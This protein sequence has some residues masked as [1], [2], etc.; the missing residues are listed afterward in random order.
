MN[1]KKVVKYLFLL[2]LIFAA[3]SKNEVNQYQFPKIISGQ[4]RSS[5]GLPLENVRVTLTTV[6][7]FNV[8]FTNQQGYYRIENVPEG[9]HRIK[10]E[11]YGYE[12]QELDVPS[13]INGVST[14]NVQLNKKVYSTPTNK[15]VSK[16]PVRIFNNRLE[17]DFD[18]DGIYVPFFVKG[19]AFSPTPIG[20]RPITPKME[21]RSIQFLK[22]LNVNTIRTYSGVRSSLLEKLAMQ[23]IYCVLGFWVDYNTDLSKPDNREK[24]KQDFIRFVYQ[25]K[26]NPGLLMWNLGNEQ[27]YQN[28]NNQYWYSLAQ[29]LALI[30]YNIEGEKYHPVVI[31]NG[32]I[33]NIGNP[34]M[35]ADDNS[36]TYIDVW[37]INLYNYNL[38]SRINQIRNK[39][40]KLVLITEFG[41]DALDN[42]TK[43][44]YETTQAVFDSLNWQQILSVADICLGGTVFEFTDEWWKDKDPWNHDYG[45]YPTNQHPDG[46]SNEEWWGLIRVLPDSD[47]DG[48]DEWI[49]REVYYMFKR[50]WKQ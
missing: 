9:K 7:N 33:F 36:L 19:V 40:I 37:G 31:N 45:G 13:A 41:I 30:A 38:A 20:N 46:Y 16:G 34:A 12:E 15:P 29:E 23:G 39:T 50:N 25:Y 43:Q 49:P 11:L 28:G 35:L 32:E 3:C 2:V 14:V 42:R 48:L 10:F 27:N 1:S 17:V 26:D 24:I 5:S 47:N 21:E 4:V 44:E 22:D 18:G 8:V 6:P